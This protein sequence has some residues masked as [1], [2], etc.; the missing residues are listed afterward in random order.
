M[1]SE[2]NFYA[3]YYSLIVVNGELFQ[4]EMRIMSMIKKCVISKPLTKNLHRVFIHILFSKDS[5]YQIHINIYSGTTV[6]VLKINNGPIRCH[7]WAYKFSMSQ[8]LYFL[9]ILGL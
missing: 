3:I 9:I 2:N 5:F 1:I 8:G 6:I 7:I 4:V